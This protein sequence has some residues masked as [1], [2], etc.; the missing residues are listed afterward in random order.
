MYKKNREN[1]DL[2]GIACSFS[3]FDEATCREIIE[4]AKTS[5]SK[6]GLVYSDALSVDNSIR[7]SEIFYVDEQQYPGLYDIV[8]QIF[9]AGNEWRFSISSVPAIQIMRYG[10]GDKYEK[11]TDWSPNNLFRKLSLSIQLSDPTEYEGGE[12]LFHAGPTPAELPYN[13]GHGCV[14]P[15]FVLHE[16]K[17]VT[18]GERWALVAWAHGEKFA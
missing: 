6:K 11:H 15:S 18:S 7:S 12:V 3:A 17:P 8:R 2:T 4:I 16:V 1:K 10:I 9:K 13:I 5:E 14:W